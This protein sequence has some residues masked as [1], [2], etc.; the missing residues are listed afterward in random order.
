MPHTRNAL[1]LLTLALF[2]ACGD[3]NNACPPSPDGAVAKD[4]V[5]QPRPDSSHDA[6]PQQGQYRKKIDE[7]VAPIFGDKYPWNK[8]VVVAV[9]S[10]KGTEIYGYGAT[11]E[12]GPPPDEN[13]LYEIAS[14]TKTFTSLVLATMVVDGAVKLDQPV[15]ELLPA[16]QVKVPQRNGIPITLQHLA[17]HTS[18]LPGMPDNFEA[19]VKDWLDP[20]PDYHAADLYSFLG[21]YTLTRDPGEAWEYSNLGVGLLG[22]ALRLKAGQTY[23]D[24]V[25]SRITQPLGMPDTVITL[26]P[27]QQARFAQ[28]Y[29]FDLEQTPAWTLDVLEGAG[30]L[31]STVKDMLTYLAAQAGIKDTPLAKAM[32][33]T[34]VPRFILDPENLPGAEIGLG[35]IIY[36]GP[37]L[38]HAGATYGFCTA[39]SFDPWSKIAAVVFT[40]GCN[41][42]FAP[43]TQLT[44]RL[45]DLLRGREVQPLELPASISVDPAALGVYA[46]L[47]RV[48]KD[49]QNFDIAVT[50]G[51]GMLKVT[52]PNPIEPFPNRKLYPVGPDTFIDRLEGDTFTFKKGSGGAYESLT[53]TWGYSNNVGEDTLARVK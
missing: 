19:T 38:W 10:E 33:L 26:S 37:E 36:P 1:L 28:G 34:Q 39:V 15:Q 8:S 16:G 35:W 53:V 42:V 21:G 7:L 2:A 11:K 4:D 46:G 44:S 23:A 13:T 25:R 27:D 30:A 3:T 22:H 24:M 52:T 32:S 29:T 51:A 40:T 49:G 45:L 47:Y 48:Q 50:L 43:D 17:T 41:V 9:M 18:G 12:G 31:R 6:T 14:N 20:Y 5:A